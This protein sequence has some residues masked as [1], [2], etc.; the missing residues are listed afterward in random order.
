MDRHPSDP[1]SQETKEA[2]P[3]NRISAHGAVGAEDGSFTPGGERRGSGR[4]LSPASGGTL[5]RELEL[6][7]MKQRLG[8][9]VRQPG[10]PISASAAS[11]ILFLTL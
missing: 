8:A 11:F 6:R 10:K 4:P 1:S 2:E 3:F 5:K 7:A 9:G